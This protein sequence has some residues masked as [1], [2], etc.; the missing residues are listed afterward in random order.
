[1]CRR[2]RVA[3]VLAIAA[4]AG[5]LVFTTFT[6]A[7]GSAARPARARDGVSVSFHTFDGFDEPATPA[8]L[9]KVGV[10]E[11]GR[12]SAKN[13]LVL[14]PGTSAS[15]AYFE[16]LAKDIAKKSPSWQVWAVERRENL[17]EDHSML[18]RAKQGKAT[19]QQL[20]EYYL[21]FLSDPSITEHYKFIDDSEVAFAREWGMRVAVEDLHRVVEAAKKRGGKV[22]MGGHS[23]GG[24]ITTAY[25]TWD[26]AGKAGARDLAGLVFIDGGSSPAP[27]SPDDASAALQAVRTGTPWLT[28]GGIAAPYAGLFNAVGSTSVHLDPKGV[29]ELQTW[30]LLPANLK[31]PVPTNNEAAY[32]FALDVKTSPTGLRAAQA[33]LGRLAASG[34]P[35]PWDR[36]GAITPLQRYADMFSGTG[37]EGHDGT[38]WYHPQRL[39]IDAGAVAAGNANPA[40]DILDVRATH[41]HDLPKGLLMYAFGAA[42]GGQRVLDGAKVLA[43]QSGIPAS[44]LTLVN[45][46]DTYAH[47][48]PAGASPKSDF[49][50]GLLPFLRKVAR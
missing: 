26:F 13:V 39:T 20:F 23:L 7:A 42:L 41:G 5:A 18:D 36:A 12:R 50:D 14:V 38:A 6:P 27:T 28:F 10:I 22:V 34:D 33:H 32:G 15:A 17:L 30:P 45:R 37:I 46:A 43:D 9:D 21:G 31:P 29:G 11:T 2:I 25:A 48:D 4:G 40:Q 3:R 8:K 35:R 1:M 24:S 16:P 49:Q 19:P 47:N 44:A